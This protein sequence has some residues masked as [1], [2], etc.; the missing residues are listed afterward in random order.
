MRFFS[1]EI[2]QRYD[3]YTFGYANYCECE[4]EDALHQLYAL[5]YLPYSGSPN[6]HNVFYMARSARVDLARF[7]LSSEN[8]RIAKKFDGEFTKERIAFKDFAVTHEFIDFCLSYFAQK[9]GASAMP[10]ARLEHILASGLMTH[11]IVYTKESKPVAYVFA[12]ADEHCEHYWFSF[13]DLSLARQSLG[14]WLMLDCLRDAKARASMHYYLGTVYGETALYK[15]NFEPLEWYDGKS[16][17]SDIKLLKERGRSDDTRTL[18]A[19]DAWKED[20]Q[21]FN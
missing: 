18:P 17:S 5:G 8:R 6:A 14:L 16:W 4:T 3:S 15:T 12:V 2:G 13:Y 9:H 1:S 7:E 20:L 19:T 11:I 21:S 10:K